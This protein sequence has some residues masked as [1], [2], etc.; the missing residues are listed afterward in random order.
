VLPATRAEVVE[1]LFE[2]FLELGA[3]AA[4]EK[5]VPV[6]ARNLR[7]DNVEF[8]EF[9]VAREERSLAATLGVIPLLGNLGVGCEDYV[10]CRAFG[11][12]INGLLSW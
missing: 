10:E 8:N 7:L 9:A 5:H 4:L 6:A 1:A 12:A 11:R 2:E 3:R